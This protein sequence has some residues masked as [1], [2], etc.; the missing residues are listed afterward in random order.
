MLE[1]CFPDRRIICVDI[2]GTG[3]LNDLKSPD[4]MEGM[5]KSIRAQL[6]TIKNLDV[7]SISMGGMIG[8]K[9]AELYP[10]E[11]G[12]LVC[13]NTSARGFSPFYQR[14]KPAAYIKIL[15]A[16]FTPARVKESIIYSLVSNKEYSEKTV[17]YWIHLDKTYPM[18]I[19]NFFRQIMAASNF[20]ITKV[21][22][23]LLFISSV[24]DRLVSYKATQAIAKAWGT[25]LIINK[26]DGHDIALDNPGWLCEQLRIAGFPSSAPTGSESN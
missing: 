16:L 22:C 21:N 9:W 8:L 13:I 19:A 24:A 18:K 14:L 11:I 4:T 2:P 6:G 3:V 25:P 20:E 26:A 10:D 7:I 15:M 12:K 17:G 1:T 23:E 5:V